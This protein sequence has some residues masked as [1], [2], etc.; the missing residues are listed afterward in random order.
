MCLTAFLPIPLVAP[1][2]TK[3][4]EN[5]WTVS[6][7]DRHGTAA[8]FASSTST[9]LVQDFTLFFSVHTLSNCLSN[10]RSHGLVQISLFFF[11]FLFKCAHVWTF[12]HL[13][14][15]PTKQ[16]YCSVSETHNSICENTTTVRDAK[17]D[18]WCSTSH[19]YKRAVEPT[20]QL[21][22]GSERTVLKFD[23]KIVR[24]CLVFFFIFV[25]VLTSQQWP[26]CW[27]HCLS[28]AFWIMLGV[29]WTACMRG[30]LKFSF[31]PLQAK[32]DVIHFFKY[33]YTRP[34]IPWGHTPLN[35][36]L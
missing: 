19:L 6:I 16:R 30:L 22:T 10:M 36:A 9:A 11:F 23:Y 14:N 28:S 1:L 4:V 12:I 31:L 13:H 3:P 21:Q 34:W 33:Q 24:K 27:T 5:Q 25:F 35:S 15:C 20:I 8:A 32:K 17:R 29:C 2:Y 18:Q 7:S 26:G